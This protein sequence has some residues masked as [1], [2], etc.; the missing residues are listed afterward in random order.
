MPATR[1]RRT[2]LTDLGRTAA[3]VVVVGFAGGCSG[4]DEPVAQVTA[5]TDPTAAPTTAST[6]PTADPTTDGASPDAAGLVVPHTV[7]L[8]IGAAYVLVRAGE[9]AIVDTGVAGSEDAIEAVLAEAGVGWGDVGH[10][11]LTHQHGDHVGSL[12]AVAGLA[13]GA[14]LYGGAADIP[15]MTAPREISAVGDGDTVFDLSIIETPGHTAGHISVHEPAAGLLV[16]GD[17]LVGNAGRV[18]GPAAQFTA[19]MTSAI[20]SVATLAE[21]DVQRILVGH[22]FPVEGGTAELAALAETLAG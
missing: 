6:D 9:A 13:S 12:E 21:L 20:A 3:G 1:T 16:T 22:G 5:P 15:N 10:V 2:F 19:D 4:G 7:D 14:A 8:G 18:A 11:I 17:A